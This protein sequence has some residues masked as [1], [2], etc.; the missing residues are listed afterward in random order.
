MSLTLSGDI[1]KFLEVY[2]KAHS[3]NY[4]W[5]GWTHDGGYAGTIGYSYCLQALRVQLVSNADEAGPPAEDSSNAA[6]Y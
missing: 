1:S 5:L 6:F 2:Y 4:G 3:S